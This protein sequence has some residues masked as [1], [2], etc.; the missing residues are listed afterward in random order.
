VQNDGWALK[1]VPES[2]RTAEVCLAA[3]KNYPDAWRY[4][5]GKQNFL[6]ALLSLF[7]KGVKMFHNIKL[8]VL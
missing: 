3:V 5:P 4:V 7:Y 8:G 1:Y 6:Y 2:L